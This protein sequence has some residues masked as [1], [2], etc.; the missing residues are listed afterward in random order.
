MNFTY[1]ALHQ[2]MFNTDWIG[3]LPEWNSKP[4]WVPS[5]RQS[6]P[7]C[8]GPGGFR[9]RLQ[10]T[11]DR[12]QRPARLEVHCNPHRR[13]R[14]GTTIRNAPTRPIPLDVP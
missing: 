2:S 14:R 1:E 5:P 9:S 10:L 3:H 12:V 7:A 13:S 4:H 6:P 11:T 8:R